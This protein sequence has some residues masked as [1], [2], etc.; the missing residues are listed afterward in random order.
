[1]KELNVDYYWF[2][3]F[4][5]TNKNENHILFNRSFH[6]EKETIMNHYNLELEKDENLLSVENFLS[7]KNEKFKEKKEIINKNDDQRRNLPTAPI[8]QRRTKKL[9]FGIKTTKFKNKYYKKKGRKRKNS[10]SEPTKRNK[11]SED[12]IRNRII[13]VFINRTQIYINSKLSKSKLKKIKKI[14]T[15]SKRYH[16]EELKKFLKKNIGEIFSEPLSDR[17]TKF[18]KDYNKNLINNLR[19]DNK[20]KEI[21]NIF[22]QTAEQM[23][24]NFINNT[25]PDFNLNEDLKKIKQEDENYAVN[26]KNNADN[27]VK[28]IYEKKGRKRR[29]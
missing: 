25:I 8:E 26:F 20:L 3:D 5:S 21:N 23:F 13:N 27:L 11:N 19:K 28:L 7:N 1:M 9:F 18:A 14:K 15:V 29:K 22:V 10:T 4:S 24:G 17:C 2:W 6:Y 16:I 12:N